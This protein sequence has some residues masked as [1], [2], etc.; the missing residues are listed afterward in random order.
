MGVP[1]NHPFEGFHELNHPAI[2]VP[3]GTP[4]YGAWPQQDFINRLAYSRSYSDRSAPG[5][6]GN[7][8][9]TNGLRRFEIH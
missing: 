5:A 3:R 8:I 7:M 6:P 1:P 9:K 4:I 2:G